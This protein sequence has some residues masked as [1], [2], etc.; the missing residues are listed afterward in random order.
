MNS[1]I[2]ENCNYSTLKKSQ[3][4]K[5]LHTEKHKRITNLPITDTIHKCNCGKI[6]KHKPSLYNHKRKCNFVSD[7]D[8]SASIVN[9]TP[10]TVSNIIDVSN[11]TMIL[12]LIKQNNTIMLENKELKNLIIDLASKV[13][14]NSTNNTFISNNSF[15]LNFFLNETCKD[16]ISMN[17][18]IQNIEIQLKELENIGNNG[19]I[20]GVTDIITTR[21]KQ[22]DITKRPVH[23]T[24]LK[25]ETLY[26]KDENTW[27]KDK[28]NEKMRN[29]ITKIANKSYRS[30]PRWREEYPE[31]KDPENAKYDF[32]IKMMR[33]VLGEIGDEQLKLDDKVIKN[34]AKHVIIN[35]S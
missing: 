32:C 27:N 14:N 6:Y 22:L 33:N 10:N 4:Y 30:I 24:D 9:N 8:K 11:N 31:C 3:Y 35:K 12:E 7:T 23:C 20:N 18:F 26:I 17:D 2:C 1:Y 15:N 28:E 29:M 16:A 25:R 21:L 5:H 19:Y 34:I 13:G